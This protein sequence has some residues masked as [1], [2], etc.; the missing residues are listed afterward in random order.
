MPFTDSD[1]SAL[2]P[3]EKKNRV[4]TGLFQTKR[5]T[6]TRIRVF[7]MWHDLLTTLP[8]PPTMEPR[9]VFSDFFPPTT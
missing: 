9:T 3:C 6:A 4:P 8:S 2:E 1:L 7:S 5:E